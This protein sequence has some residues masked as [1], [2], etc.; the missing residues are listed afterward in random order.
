VAGAMGTAKAMA[1]RP[2]MATKVVFIVTEYTEKI[3]YCEL[4]KGCGY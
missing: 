2:K 4:R 3:V 1:M